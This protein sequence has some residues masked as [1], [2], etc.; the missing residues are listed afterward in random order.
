M[1]RLLTDFYIPYSLFHR[2]FLGRS[3]ASTSMKNPLRKSI[4][5][6]NILK[7]KTGEIYCFIAQFIYFSP[8]RC[9]HPYFDIFPFDQSN[10]NL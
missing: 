9:N 1:S 5:I 3:F 10:D 4:N 6:L 7:D 8:M 2:H